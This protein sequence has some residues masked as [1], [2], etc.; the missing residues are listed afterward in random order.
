M[1]L[2][3]VPKRLEVFDGY[4]VIPNEGY[5]FVG[6]SVSLKTARKVKEFMKL[7]LSAYD[8]SKT[9]VKLEVDPNRV[10]WREG[11]R[12]D[13]NDEGVRIVGHDD[14]GVYYGIMTLKQIVRQNEGKI[15]H[16]RIIDWPDFPERGVMLDISRDKVP[17][18][19]TLFDLID[20]LSEFK[21]NHFQL[22]T[23][24]TFAYRDHEIVWKDYSPITGEEI[25][26]LDEYARERHVE[27]VP[28][29]NSFGHMSKWLIHDDYKH[30]AESPDGFTFPWGDK[31][32]VPFSLSPA[33]PESLNF[34]ESL[35]EELLPHFTSG[36]FNVGCDETFDL[37]Q[38][39]SKELCEK[40]GKG[41]VYL[42]FLLKIHKLVEKHGK[43]M[44][45]WGDIIKNYPDLV[46]ELPDGVIALIWGYEKD[47]PFDRECEIF[48]KS[49]V[50]FYV[51]P[52]TSTWNS[53]I[54]RLEN[55]M[56]NI[57]NAV[58][59]G[60]KWGAIGVLNTDWGDNG[61]WQ[62]LPFSFPLY[63]YGA[64]LSWNIDSDVP[65]KDAMN[66]H[67]FSDRS[68]VMGDVMELLENAYLEVGVDT[69]NSNVFALPL[70][71]PQRLSKDNPY[72]K[73]M[74]EDEH[75]RDGLEKARVRIEK[76]LGMLE[77]ADIGRKD[78]ELVEREL[79]N[80][81]DLA[82]HSIR[83]L[84]ELLETPDGKI[85]SIPKSIRLKLSEDLDR[86]AQDYKN[87]WLERNREGGLKF[88]LEKLLAAKKLYEM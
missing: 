43:T 85:T 16:L 56:K 60:S 55:S 19:E 53:I 31:L 44:L 49:G 24:H 52:G 41:R 46:G 39:R 25:L 54:G 88:S 78:S 66:L 15:P 4:V 82:L 87:I 2:V 50:P 45:F 36:K 76:A 35:Y 37:C 32:S 11:Y 10:P 38:G 67:V 83:L 63:V 18:M 59:N 69:F 65:L 84:K 61:H 62:H 3:P 68:G 30:M 33:V 58:K 64:A 28:N 12:M 1:V 79:R 74:M 8:G 34:L 77:K 22:Y 81:A 29:Q 14:A 23:E 27:L 20:M 57:E 26:A 48:A 75:L 70:I 21:I 13:V 86:I 9:F 47:H 51:C 5:I 17:R 80:G 72:L 6:R 71:Y 42:D 7:Q 40:Y 73:K